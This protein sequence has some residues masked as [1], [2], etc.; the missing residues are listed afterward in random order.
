MKE[1]DWPGFKGPEFQRLSGVGLVPLVL[2]CAR[3][4]LFVHTTLSPTFTVK[5]GAW[6]A[7][8]TIVTAPLASNGEAVLAARATD[9]PI[10]ASAA[11]SKRPRF[12]IP[13]CS[14]VIV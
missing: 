8:S 3:V 9:T 1:N 5:L 12:S 14:G 7:L 2:V 13:N 6:K 4:P 11:A 10:Q